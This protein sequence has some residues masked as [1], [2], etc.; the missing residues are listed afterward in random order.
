[1][2]EFPDPPELT[3]R[4]SWRRRSAYHAIGAII[5]GMTRQRVA[6]VGA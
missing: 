4:R 5:T 1:M 6:T 3:P 2:W